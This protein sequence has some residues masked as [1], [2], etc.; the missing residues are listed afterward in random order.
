MKMTSAYANKML[1]QLAED[2]VF[3]TNK[4]ANSCV[5]TAAAGETPVVPD[6]DYRQVADKI[7]EI[8]RKVCVIKHAINL[9]NVMGEVTV[10]GE[11]MPIDMVL[12]RMAQLNSRKN[13]LDYM[14]KQ[15]PKTRKETVSYGNRVPAPEYQYINYDLELI[16]QEYENISEKIM[17]LQLELDKYN[18]TAEFEVEL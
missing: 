10:D 11:K 2:K 14:R 17:K 15:E 9:A 7:A 16:K 12:V 6:Y 1:K 5:Y 4:E 8:D 13:M 18:Q 3:W